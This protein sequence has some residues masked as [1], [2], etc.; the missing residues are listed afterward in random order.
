[1]PSSARRRR[2]AIAAA[3]AMAG[4]AACGGP[5]ADEYRADAA[6]ICRDAALATDGIKAPTRSTVPAIIDYFERLV[7]VT[8]RSTE[9]FDALD[10][11][12]DLERAHQEVVEA[13]RRASAEVRE[14]VA[15]LGR[16]QDAEAVL[17]SAQT[18]IER[19]TEQADAAASRLGVPDCTR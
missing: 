6:A 16:G 17:G 2:A 9:R 10:P 13:N 5:S 7:A 15:A 3:L 8:D 11:P 18:S 12:Q 14:V 19:A 1:M 4:L